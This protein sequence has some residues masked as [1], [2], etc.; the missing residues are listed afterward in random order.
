VRFLGRRR[1]KALLKETHVIELL[2]AVGGLEVNDGFE[3]GSECW[4]S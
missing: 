1:R 3:A 2:G 4:S